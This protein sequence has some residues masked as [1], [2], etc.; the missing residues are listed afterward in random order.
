MNINTIAEMISNIEI[1]PTLK[2]I[3][4]SPKLFDLIRH[5]FFEDMMF[6][7]TYPIEIVSFRGVDIEMDYDLFGYTYEPVY[8]ENNND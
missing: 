2:K 1:P 4:V 7:A 8:E 3:K 5:H 6:A